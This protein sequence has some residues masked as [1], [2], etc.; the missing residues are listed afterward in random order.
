MKT[1]YSLIAGMMLLAAGSAQA[2]V[3]VIMSAKSGVAELTKQ[4]VS[5][6]F[7]GKAQSF[8]DGK[9]AVP[10]DHAE[11]S[12]LRDEFHGKV[13]GKNGAQL[14]A[15]W[16]KQLF[17]GKG[18]PPKEMSNSADVKKLLADN[19]NMIGYADKAT[20]DGSVKTVFVP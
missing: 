17:S 18:T 6:I 13:T 11:S 19:P 16:S 1:N 15:F 5:D 10:I 9:P 3:V 2:D 14:K 8:P 4:Q 12:P 20:V 7:L